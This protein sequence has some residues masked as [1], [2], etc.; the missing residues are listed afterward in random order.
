VVEWSEIVKRYI[1]MAKAVGIDSTHRKFAVDRWIHR[2]NGRG[3]TLT[4][5]QWEAMIATTGGC[6]F[7]GETNRKYITMEHLMPKSIGGG[8]TAENIVPACI[9]C[10]SARGA[11][12][13][14]SVTLFLAIEWE[15]P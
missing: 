2:K 4:V 15:G 10:N 3:G 11:T 5:E 12:F 9:R 13:N 7:C 6:V 14:V 8:F 1:R